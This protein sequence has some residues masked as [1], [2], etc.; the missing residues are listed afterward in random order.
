MNP[1][2]FS[3]IGLACMLIATIT[4]NRWFH[5]AGIILCFAGALGVLLKR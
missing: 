1:L 2:V 4:R 5:L 3:F